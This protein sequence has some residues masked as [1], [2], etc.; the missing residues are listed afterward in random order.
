M[1]SKAGQGVLGMCIM[2]YLYV[3][4]YYVC[5][6][7]WTGQ[8]REAEEINLLHAGRERGRGEGCLRP[9]GVV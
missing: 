8:S 7:A 5:M 9:Y 1:N 2:Y 4:M 3:F 6:H